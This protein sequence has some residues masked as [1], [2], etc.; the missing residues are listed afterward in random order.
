MIDDHL[1]Q[2]QRGAGDQR[3]FDLALFQG[4]NR[5]SVWTEAGA[6]P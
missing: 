5:I 2:V 4:G 6:A 3:A 1:L